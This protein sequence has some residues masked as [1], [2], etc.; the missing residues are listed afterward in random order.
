MDYKSIIMAQAF[1]GD[2]GGGGTPSVGTCE[3]TIKN[4]G[5]AAAGFSAFYVNDNEVKTIDIH[6]GETKTVTVDKGTSLT[7]IS[8][9][10]AGFNSLNGTTITRIL[11]S[12]TAYTDIAFITQDDTFT[13][14]Q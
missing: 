13:D 12:D 2:G 6:D 1:G 8:Y 4:S 7:I 11:T 10:N 5:G 9:Y 14:H 3:I